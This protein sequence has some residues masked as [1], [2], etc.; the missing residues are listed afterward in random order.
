VVGTAVLGAGVGTSS[1]AAADPTRQL[2][3]DAAGAEIELDYGRG[4]ARF[5][6][7]PAG[8]AGLTLG[9]PPD[10]VAQAFADRYGALLGVLSASDLRVR[11]VVVDALG[12]SHVR[13]TQQYAGLPVY[14]SD[15][16]M[17]FDATGQLTRAQAA[18]VPN[19]HLSTTPALGEAEATTVA[20]DHTGALLAD[21]PE[22]V[23]FDLGL[24]DKLAMRPRLAYAIGVRGPGIDSTVIVDAV[25]GS[26]LFAW[27][28]IHEVL[29]RAT[30]EFG[31]GPG[32]L[33]WQESDGPYAGGDA[34]M[35]GLIDFTEDTFD[36][37][38]NI[39]GGTYE[40]YDGDSAPME[41]VLYAPLQCPNAQWNGTTTN[42]CTGLATDDVVGHEWA[43]GYTQLNHNLIYAYEPGAL[44]ESY[45][46]IFGEAIDL[47]NGAG[48]DTPGDPRPVD[49]CTSNAESVRWLI[50]EDT[51]GLGGAIRDMWDP[52]C[53]AHPGRVGDFEYFCLFSGEFFDNGGVHINSGVPNHGFALLVDG[54][55]FNGEAVP[56]IGMAKALALYWRA[57]TV[58]QGQVSGFADHAA[59]LETSCDDLIGTDVF[60][61]LTGMAS[62]EVIE[63]AD[64]DAVTSAMTATEMTAP[65]PCGEEPLFDTSD[66]PPA[67]GEDDGVEVFVEDFEDGLAGWSVSNEGVGPDYEPR[68]WEVLDTPPEGANG[69]A[70]FA[71][72][73]I[74]LGDCQ[75]E[76]S[77]AGVMHLDAPEIVLPKEGDPVL[78][79]SHWLA[80]E[81]LLDGGNLEVSVSG[82]PFVDVPASAFI[83]NGYNAQL[84][85]SDNPLSG[86]DAF[87]GSDASVPTGTWVTSIVDLSGFA[88]SG[89]TVVVRFDFGVNICN[90]LFGWYVDDV[91]VAQCAAEDTG[92]TTGDTTD[93]N[94]TDDTGPSV[95]D[96]GDSTDSG[97]PADTTV[98]GGGTGPD[99]ADGTTGTPLPPS[100][101]GDTSSET[102]EEPGADTDSGG[103]A[104]TTEPRT[105]FP[106]LLLL[107]LVLRGR[108][109][110][111][112]RTRAPSRAR[113][114]RAQR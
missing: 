74:Y 108:A 83:F 48:L 84:A 43:H 69:M 66:P 16:R 42:Y 102:G 14:G 97:P 105:T 47:L 34:Q 54:G 6:R 75:Q 55:T 95:D 38:A 85:F 46:D 22:L 70:A 20:F 17:H 40:S 36:L 67:C 10:V 29:E 65:N 103:C 62:G 23:V 35:A 94:T 110:T 15:V 26:V 96:T 7:M 78:S 60:D 99:P 56:A 61:P 2:R 49:T 98:D 11:D 18:T 45:S 24:I 50:G 90:G 44:N 41:A 106:W 27:S 31:Y 91:R 64:C 73:D 39:S 52:T 21:A 32:F 30:Y 8:V 101:G 107:P 33:A 53:M 59:A 109:R 3:A 37:F 25:D 93:G 80:S 111:P 82:G 1:V 5:A 28:H 71:N 79:F 88:G 76:I 86:E 51:Q 19:L 13:F 100:D 112:L 68:D 104:C 4:T 92:D 114:H 81:P 57:M 77:Q 113:R 9:D 87:T 63:Q 58:Y 72:G 89:D 12:H